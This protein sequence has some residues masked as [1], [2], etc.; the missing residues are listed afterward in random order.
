MSVARWVRVTAGVCAAT[1]LYF[2]SPNEPLR[3][4]GIAQA[5]AKAFYTRKRVHGRWISGRFP[6]RTARSYAKAPRND[7]RAASSRATAIGT[8]SLRAETAPEK[9]KASPEGAPLNGLALRAT[10]DLPVPTDD[11]LLKLRDALQTRAVQL[12]NVE[13]QQPTTTGSI[14]PAQRPRSIIF[15]F[16]RSTKTTSY[17]GGMNVEEPFDTALEQRVAPWR[18]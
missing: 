1:L 2:Y 7:A 18:R 16:E 6:K 10:L 15:D 9:E 13:G 12:A 3:G 11:G 14:G 8:P 5:D 4:F 17:A